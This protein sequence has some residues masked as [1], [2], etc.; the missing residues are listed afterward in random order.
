MAGWLWPSL[1]LA[2]TIVMALTNFG[3]HYFYGP[4][5]FCNKSAWHF[6]TM[7]ATCWLAFC[8]CVPQEH[9]VIGGPGVRERC[10]AAQL[11]VP[12]P[13]HSSTS[14]E[15]GQKRGGTPT[16]TGKAPTPIFSCLLKPGVLV[17]HCLVV[18]F[19]SSK[20]HHSWFRILTLHAIMLSSGC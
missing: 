15:D 19:S 11:Q 18:A 5:Y 8:A 10:C 1:I 14:G 20:P 12:R 13:A 2:L 4:H 7:P 6:G 16:W 3:P 17:P 9:D